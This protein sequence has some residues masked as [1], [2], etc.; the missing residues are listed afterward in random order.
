[1][2]NSSVKGQ[3][4]G[5]L[6]QK[7]LADLDLELADSERDNSHVI[8]CVHHN[9]IPVQAAWLQ[10]HCLRNSDEMF[11]ITDRYSHVRGILY[12]HIHQEFDVVRN[13]VK[14][15]ATPSTCIQFHPTNDEFTIDN[16]NPGYRWLELEPDGAIKSQVERVEE[17]SYNIDFTS[18]GY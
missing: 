12:G 14:I 3:V 6:D 9:C 7:E 4:Y 18:T 11:S 13:D 8:A 15:M 1:M 5:L 16:A 17:K 10:Q 2:L